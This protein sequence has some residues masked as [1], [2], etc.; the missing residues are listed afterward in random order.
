MGVSVNFALR[1]RNLRDVCFSTV[2][3]YA[4][5]VARSARGVA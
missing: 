4:R 3:S 2:R 1:A 5:R